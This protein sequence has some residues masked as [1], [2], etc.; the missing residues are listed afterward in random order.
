MYI[1]APE[2]MDFWWVKPRKAEPASLEESTID[3][4]HAGPHKNDP[5][6]SRALYAQFADLFAI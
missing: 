2:A 5:G 3:R 6:R 1:A 4:H